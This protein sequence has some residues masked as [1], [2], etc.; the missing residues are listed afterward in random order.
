MY[1]F[2]IIVIF[3][4]LMILFIPIYIF[5]RLYLFDS[6]QEQHSI[7]RN[8]PI[9]GNVRYI[10]E[11]IGSVLRQYL[12]NNNTEGKPINRREFEYVYKAAKYS[13]RMIGYGYERDF[14]KKGIYIVNNMFPSQRDELKIKQEPKIP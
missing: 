14:S 13:R 11:K 3:I 6:H 9:L 1:T 5:G 2:L 10:T 12:F 8:Y 7:L 4:L